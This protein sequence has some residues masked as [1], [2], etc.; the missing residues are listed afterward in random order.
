MRL[1][2]GPQGGGFGGREFISGT[3]SW[4]ISVDF[5]VW[6]LEK[7]SSK[8]TYRCKY[9]YIYSWWQGT[10]IISG[11]NQ[12]FLNTFHLRAALLCHVFFFSGP[13]F[14]QWNCKPLTTNCLMAVLSFHRGSIANRVDDIESSGYKCGYYVYIKSNS[15]KLLSKW[16]DVAII[17][18]K[19]IERTRVHRTLL[20][21]G[22]L[23]EINPFCRST[24]LYVLVN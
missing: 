3:F 8:N 21:G 7:C 17:P 6:W 10:G 24:N 1:K 20:I 2:S 13:E 22:W 18:Y 16:V 4:E 19:N 9:T 23:M 11:I 5:F 14:P 12:V 15:Y